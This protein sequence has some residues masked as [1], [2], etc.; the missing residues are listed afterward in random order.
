MYN[1]ESVFLIFLTRE[2]EIPPLSFIS[3]ENGRKVISILVEWNSYNRWD[4]LK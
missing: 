1:K 2:G 3:L 4:A